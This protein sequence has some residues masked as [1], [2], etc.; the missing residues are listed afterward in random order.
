MNRQM[1]ASKRLLQERAK[2]ALEIASNGEYDGMCDP[3]CV[4]FCKLV[5]SVG[6]VTEGL[7]SVRFL[8]SEP[9]YVA[10]L[11]GDVVEFTS[12]EYVIID[13]T[14]RQ[15]ED[16]LQR[17]VDEIVFVDS[18]DVRWDEW[19]REFSLVTDRRIQEFR[20]EKRQ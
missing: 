20:A 8:G 2:Q 7:A 11:Q 18:N 6:F 19:Y 1:R 10:V 15:F 17:N 12:A 14:V 9:H 5:E 3:V 4:E 13:P 16:K